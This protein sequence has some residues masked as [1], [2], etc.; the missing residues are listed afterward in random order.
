MLIPIISILFSATYDVLYDTDSAI[1]GFQFDVTGAEL[2]DVSGGD[3]AASGFSVFASGDT[4]LS[5]AFGGAS[6]PAGSGVLVTIEVGDG[7]PCVVNLVL[8]GPS[9][10]TLCGPPT[11]SSNY[12]ECSMVNC[13]SV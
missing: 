5:F 10:T 6:I 9:G 3:A 4:A 13:L 2:L 12:E 7:D 8:S 1:Y 11:G